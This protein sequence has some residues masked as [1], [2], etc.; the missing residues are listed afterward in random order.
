MSAAGTGATLLVLVRIVDVR[1]ASFSRV[2][3]FADSAV[4]LKRGNVRWDG[5]HTH[6]VLVAISYVR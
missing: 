5:V 2:L 3:L 1:Q 6:P 4:L